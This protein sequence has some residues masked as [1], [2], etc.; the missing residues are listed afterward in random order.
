M[1]I[2]IRIGKDSS[3]LGSTN[4]QGDTAENKTESKK[5]K[6]LLLGQPPALCALSSGALQ[7][8]TTQKFALGE[9]LLFV[10]LE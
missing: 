2:S 9:D 3:K 7:F 10:K 1:A 5:P 8:A 4:L 6:P